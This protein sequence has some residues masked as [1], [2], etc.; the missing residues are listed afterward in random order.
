MAETEKPAEST[1]KKATTARKTTTPRK[2]T[3]APKTTPVS[4]PQAVEYTVEQK[5]ALLEAYYTLKNANLPIPPDVQVVEQWLEEQ[6]E[7]DVQV[8]QARATAEAEKIAQ[9]NVAGPWFVRNCHHTAFNFRLDRQTERRRVE[10]KPRG[11][12]GDLHPLKDE[13]LKDP[14][15]ISN[16]NLG[17]IEVIPAGEAQLIIEKQTHNASQRVH[18]PLAIL[19][20]ENGQEYAPGAVKVA[21]EFNSQGVTVAYTDPNVLQGKVTDKQLAHNANFGGLTRPGQAQPQVPT[22]YSAFVPTGGNPAIVSQSP[23]QAIQSDIANRAMGQKE[24]TMH[25]GPGELTVTVA[26][27]QKVG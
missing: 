20:N 23:H 21:A 9:A 10:L 8:E 22:V 1:P 26:P 11:F 24:H 17:I 2:R 5:Q 14:I 12:P 7:R 18:T 27:T 25:R 6:Q 4:A 16:V 15:L 3:T 19:R 13:D